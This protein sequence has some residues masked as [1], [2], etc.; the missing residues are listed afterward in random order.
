MRSNLRVEP[1]EQ[2]IGTFAVFTECVAFHSL[3][4]DPTMNGTSWLLS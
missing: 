3:A 1:I 2:Q 4:F